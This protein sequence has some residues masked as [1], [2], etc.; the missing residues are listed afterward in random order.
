[1]RDTTTFTLGSA[2]VTLTR[3]T[4]TFLGERFFAWT[5]Y[6]SK[7]FSFLENISIFI[8]EIIKD[9]FYDVTP[10]RQIINTLIELDNFTWECA[11]FE[12]INRHLHSLFGWKGSATP[13]LSY[14]ICLVIFLQHYWSYFAWRL[15]HWWCEGSHRDDTLERPYLLEHHFING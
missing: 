13:G 5:G 1:M 7:I 6:I 9:I 12:I 3:C 15:H 10:K 8:L 2:L 11:S 4:S 14:K